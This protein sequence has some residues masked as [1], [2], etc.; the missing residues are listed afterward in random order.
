MRRMIAFYGVAQMHYLGVLGLGKIYGKVIASFLYISVGSA[1]SQFT[2]SAS[3]LSHLSF[4]VKYNEPDW[5]FKLR[6]EKLFR[7]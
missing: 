3:L 5:L 1:G 6:I 2:N 7:L 4:H